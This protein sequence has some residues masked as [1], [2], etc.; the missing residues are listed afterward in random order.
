MG[1]ECLIGRPVHERREEDF[2]I[3]AGHRICVS[4]CLWTHNLYVTFE[5]YIMIM[6]MDMDMDMSACTI[7]VHDFSIYCALLLTD[8]YYLIHVHACAKIM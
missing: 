2:I 7:H 3:V 4:A 8:S 5:V 6:I 1:S